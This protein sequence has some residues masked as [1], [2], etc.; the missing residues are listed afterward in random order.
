MLILQGELSCAEK[1]ADE[2]LDL[3]PTVEELIPSAG[4]KSQELTQKLLHLQVSAHLLKNNAQD[5]MTAA[6]Q[7]RSLAASSGDKDQEAAAWHAIANVYQIQE[8]DGA[9][10]ADVLQA[11]EKAVDTYRGVSNRNGEAAALNTVARAQL[12]E[13]KVSLG[14][15]TANESL[16]IFR[17]LK[18]SRGMVSALE[19][20]VQ[21]HAIQDNPMAGLQAANKELEALKEQGNKRGQ[22][23]VLDMITQTQA[24]LGQPRS[25][26]KT[27]RQALDIYVSLGDK[28]GEGS[29]LH[30][31]A[32]MERSLGNM[33]D[34]SQLAEKS[35]RCFKDAGSKWGEDQALT[36]LSVV[37]V[38]R[39][40]PEKSPKR[41]EVQRALKELAKAIEQRKADD[42]K[43]AETR[44]NSMENMVGDGE[45]QGVLT[46]ILM[47]DPTAVEFLEEQGWK[48]QKD[49][50]NPSKIKM[51]PHKGFYLHM[52]MTG[53]NFG[54]QFRPVNPYRVGNPGEDNATSC[55]ASFLPETE[56]WQ[57][58]MGYRPGLLDSCLQCGASMAFP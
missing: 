4:G 49:T 36:T 48:F 12:R 28:V 47:R 10:P 16:S 31:M 32:E 1:D 9:T 3:V 29:M 56:A 18:Q 11:A 14:L 27:A 34:A 35:L 5:A 15:Q 45:I 8:E 25:A 38:Q 44:L 52:I 40:Q 7:L 13:E 51:Y 41:A 33:V 6:K 21:A 55:S 23:D 17:D 54:P 42:L 2:A 22:A 20:I 30:T 37:L 50:T 57:M 58:D 24:M 53:M 39:G 46:P 43:D 26:T 19:T